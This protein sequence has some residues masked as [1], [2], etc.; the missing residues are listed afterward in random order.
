M[1]KICFYLKGTLFIGI[2]SAI[3]L[4][5]QATLTPK[6][7]SLFTMNDF[8]NKPEHSLDVI[9]CGSSHM[10]FGLNANILT[11]KTGL[12]CFSVAINGQK[13]SYTT[14][15]VKE[16][17]K[18]QSPQ[19]VIVD[20]YHFARDSQEMPIVDLHY[21]VDS[22]LWSLSK[23]RGI[24][25]IVPVQDQAELFFPLIRYHSRWMALT[26]DDFAYTYN[27][28]VFDGSGNLGF[29]ELDKT[30][31]LEYCTWS[32]KDK[33]ELSEEAALI[34]EELIDLSNKHGFKLIFLNL[35]YANISSEYMA[36]YNWLYD[37]C[38]D[39]GI[40]YLD[41]NFNQ[42]ESII[43]Y[44]TDFADSGHLNKYG[45][46]KISQNFSEYF[47]NLLNEQ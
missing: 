17:L 20:A 9:M 4:T 24:L 38:K 19:F 8:Y 34:L 33:T 46:E 23:I 5:V 41:Y 15:Y 44:E 37:F 26:K 1:K 14:E 2:F 27:K 32:D 22:L 16:V 29:R 13:L 11:E 39:K 3:F 35:P 12:S 31:T 30:E 25:N 28:T 42:F 7:H 10:V 36:R 18:T 45:A 43:N 47:I 21:S 40:S 6:N